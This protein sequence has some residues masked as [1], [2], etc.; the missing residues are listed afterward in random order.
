MQQSK[1]VK[2]AKFPFKLGK[3]TAI[4]VNLT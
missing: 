1:S 2:F 4:Y 3:D